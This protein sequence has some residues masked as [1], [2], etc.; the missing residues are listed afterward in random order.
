MHKLESPNGQKYR[1]DYQLWS[2]MRTVAK[3]GTKKRNAIPRE[4]VKRYVDQLVPRFFDDGAFAALAFR[5]LCSD[6]DSLFVCP[7]NLSESQRGG[8][9]KP[10]LHTCGESHFK[11]GGE[12][13]L[14]VHITC[15]LESLNGISYSPNLAC[16]AKKRYSCTQASSDELEPASASVRHARLQD[17]PMAPEVSKPVRRREAKHPETRA[18]RSA[19]PWQVASH[20]SSP[21]QRGTDMLH[22]LARMHAPIRTSV[23]EDL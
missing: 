14:T 9:R 6:R 23:R 8:V 1:H 17:V 5:S 19:S 20:H 7:Q 13:T 18:C 10:T 15:P 12:S 2:L 4:S 21:E 11:A 3:K 16:L 22:T